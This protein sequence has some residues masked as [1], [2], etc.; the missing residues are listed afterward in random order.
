MALAKKCDICGKLYE[1]YNTKNN[2]NEVNGY[3]L[4]NIDELGKYYSHHVVDCC[5]NCMDSIINH[6]KILKNQGDM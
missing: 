6:L 5:P 3:M 2:T 1:S 4:V